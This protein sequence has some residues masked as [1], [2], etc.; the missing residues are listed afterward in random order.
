MTCLGPGLSSIS[1]QIIRTIKI[2]KIEKKLTSIP[3]EFSWNFGLFSF[4][5]NRKLN[6]PI[7]MG[8]ITTLTGIT[9]RRN[10]RK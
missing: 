4:A 1:P 2:Q 10:S 3:L 5:K 8:Q 9:S 7:P 6:F